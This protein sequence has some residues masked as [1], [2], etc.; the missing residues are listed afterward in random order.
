MNN[1]ISGIH[2][3]GW[4]VFC[5]SDSYVYLEA[6]TLPG[7]CWQR[8]DIYFLT[9]LGNRL[10]FK[11]LIKEILLSLS[12]SYSSRSVAWVIQRLAS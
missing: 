8:K 4:L 3:P 10:I 2:D 11:E 9:C 1:L 6:T 12:K 5:F 7:N